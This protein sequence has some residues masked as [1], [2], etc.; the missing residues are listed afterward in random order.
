[1]KSV[2]TAELAPGMILGEDIIYEGET[3]YPKDTVLNEVVIKRLKLNSIENAM[4]KEE[5]DMAATHYERVRFNEDFKLFA[6]KHARN[7]LIYK[8]LMQ[9]FLETGQEIASPSLLTMYN[10]MTST[11]SYG[12]ELLDFL[13]NLIPNEDELTYTHCLNSALLAGIFAGWNGLS[14]ED[15]EGLIL[16][17]FY[18][19]I[20]KL[21][22][23]YEILWKRGKLTE[24]EFALVKKHPVIGYAMLNQ[25]SLDQKIKNAVI[26]HHERMNGSGYPYHM[27]GS[28]IEL[29]ARYIAIIDTYT[30]MASPRSY[31]EAL[32]P[33]QILGYFERNIQDYDTELLLPLMKHIGDA[34]IGSTVQLSDGSVWEVVIIHPNAKSRPILKNDKSQVLDLLEHSELQIVK[35]L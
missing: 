30:A 29:Y 33:L 13:Y 6:D 18:Y 22:L 8:R 16:S 4:I 7:L 31:R 19:D 5:I 35:N 11:Y 27:K 20:G 12:S 1:M 26:M 25:T 24:E 23:P 21:K 15:T 32:T 9:N 14:K 3:L 10:T 2:T 17:C 28:G 34:Q